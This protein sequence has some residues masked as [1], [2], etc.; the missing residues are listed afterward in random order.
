MALG[1][2]K[3]LGFEVHDLRTDGPLPEL[4]GQAATTADAD[5]RELALGLACD[6]LTGSGAS[7][8]EATAAAD[9]FLAWLAEG[10]A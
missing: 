5:R 2:L 1:Y 8:S 9:L 4:T 7:A 10:S 3:R 6:L